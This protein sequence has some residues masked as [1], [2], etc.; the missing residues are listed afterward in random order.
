LNHRLRKILLNTAPILV[1]LFFIWLTFRK[2]TSADWRQM[3]DSFA[4]ARYGWVLLSL[5]MGFFSHLSRAYRWRYLLEP[6]GYKPGFFNSVLTIFTAYLVNLGIPR[7]GEFVRVAGISNYEDIPY[8]K[9]LGTVITERLVDLLMLGLIILAGLAFQYDIIAERLRPVFSA[10]MPAVL[11]VLGI[12]AVLAVVFFHLVRRA[13]SGFFFQV[14]QRLYG[15]WE[16]IRSVFRM[17]KSG[18]FIAHTL[19]IWSM[20]VLM[21]YVMSFA[22]PE[23]SGLSFAAV[24]SGFIIGALSMSATN[25]GLGSYPYGVQQVLV[26]Y[27]IASHSALAFGL[28]MWTAQTLM[29]IILGGLS[30][31]L[32]PLFNK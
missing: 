30:F 12:L 11:P 21:F 14:K 9:A 18:W 24:I 7:A 17:K 28:M 20:Y 13:E 6:M 22:L 2:F 27:G 26:W 23:T 5:V 31:I 10:G 1:G 16:G 4:E 25:G 15:V 29:V 3:R 8:D 19:F 32:L